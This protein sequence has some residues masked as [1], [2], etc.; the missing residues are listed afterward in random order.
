MLPEDRKTPGP[1]FGNAHYAEHQRGGLEKV[2]NKFRLIGESIEKE[3]AQKY[4]K[5]LKIKAPSATQQGFLPVRR[6]ASRR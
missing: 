6:E 4:F 5:T 2:K 1:A 3:E